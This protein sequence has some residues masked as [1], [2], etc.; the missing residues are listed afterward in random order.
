MKPRGFTLIEVMIVVAI[1]G[2]VTAIAL[3]SYSSYVLR[4]K[5]T[6]C[7]AALM[8][9]MQQQERF[10]TQQNTYLAFSSTAASIPMKQFSGDSLAA[11]ACTIS[12][13]ACSGTTIAACVSLTATPVKSDAE[14]GSI[15]LRS[16]GT[17]GCTGTNQ[18]KCW[19]N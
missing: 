16:D 17:R 8:Q 3:P 1:I 15:S 19:T 9:V 5:R 7:R 4:S 2:I 14:V 12:A 11:S 10:F 6:E 18:T 13:A